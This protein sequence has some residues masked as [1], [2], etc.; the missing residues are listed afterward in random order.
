M[1]NLNRAEVRS[2]VWIERGDVVLLS[3]WRISLLEAISSEG[4]LTRA[5]TLL[6]VPYRTVWERVRQME[7]ELGV[8]LVVTESGGAAGGSSQITPLARELIARFNRLTLDIRELI[9]RRF[10]VEFSDLL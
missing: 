8:E 1:D 2:K 3:E 7:S 9:E 5:A 6:G 4:S 10:A